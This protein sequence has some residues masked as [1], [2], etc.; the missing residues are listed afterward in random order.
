MW[1]KLVWSICKFLLKRGGINRMYASIHGLCSI[2]CWSTNYSL[3]FVL[4]FLFLIC[5]DF[6]LFRVVIVGSCLWSF[7]DGDVFG[8]FLGGAVAWQGVDGGRRCEYCL[9]AL[10]VLKSSSV[11]WPLHGQRADRPLNILNLIQWSIISYD[12]WSCTVEISTW[13]TPAFDPNVRL[14]IHIVSSDYNRRV[15]IAVVEI[16]LNHGYFFSLG[17]VE[18]QSEEHCRETFIFDIVGY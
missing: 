5:K 18:V 15:L 17:L 8:P 14:S 7:G 3:S 2:L 12:L 16:I 13:L 10:Y 11:T 4:F 6:K 9:D 1:K